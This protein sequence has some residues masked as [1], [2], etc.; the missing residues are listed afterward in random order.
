MEGVE[1]LVLGVGVINLMN[2][3]MGGEFGGG[4]FA[5]ENGDGEMR[6]LL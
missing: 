3:D 6:I 2:F 5:G 1:E 4:A